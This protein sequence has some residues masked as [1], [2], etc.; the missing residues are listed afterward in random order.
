MTETLTEP[1]VLE[2][3]VLETPCCHSLHNRPGWAHHHHGPA[4]HWLHALHNCT[5]GASIYPACAPYVAYVRSMTEQVWQCPNCPEAR[6]GALMVY[7]I[8]PVA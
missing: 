7:V 8:G 4:T 5:G 2:A 1:D 3:V 6:L